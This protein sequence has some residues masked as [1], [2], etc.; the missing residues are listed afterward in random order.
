P[1]LDLTGEILPE[2]KEF[3]LSQAA[4]LKAAKID[5]KVPEAQYN[6]AQITF[7][8]KDYV[9]ARERYEALFSQTPGEDKNQA[10]Q[11]IK[12][13]IYMTLLLEGKDRRAQKMM[14]QFQCTGD[15][16]ARY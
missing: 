9:K 11:L 16:P 8:K 14:E 2:Q 10:A 5:P 6:L 15:T 3:D 1:I 7:K 12:F 13:K 4:F